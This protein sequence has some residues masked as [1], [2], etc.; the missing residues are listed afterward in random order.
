M[1]KYVSPKAQFVEFKQENVLRTSG[2]LCN[3]NIV[4]PS[5]S[6]CPTF[7][8]P[9]MYGNACADNPYS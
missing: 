3:D 8:C 2:E 1:K 4:C 5:D 7:V 9:N 6:A